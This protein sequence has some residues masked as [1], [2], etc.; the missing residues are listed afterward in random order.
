MR[1]QGHSGLVDLAIPLAKPVNETIAKIAAAVLHRGTYVLNF[2]QVLQ[3]RPASNPT[4]IAGYTG[5]R[6]R[7]HPIY[8]RDSKYLGAKCNSL[9]R[10]DSFRCKLAAPLVGGEYLMTFGSLVLSIVVSISLIQLHSQNS[11]KGSSQPRVIKNVQAESEVVSAVGP[12]DASMDS[13][14]VSRKMDVGENT[15]YVNQASPATQVTSRQTDR[16]S[17]V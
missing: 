10:T 6:Q 15:G 11:Q 2:G 3:V 5:I 14:V 4:E 9:V 17:V 7:G 16:K 13:A 8:F 1:R 12:I